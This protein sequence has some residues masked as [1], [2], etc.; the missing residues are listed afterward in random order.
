MTDEVNATLRDA[1]IRLAASTPAALLT[2]EHCGGNFYAKRRNT[3]FCSS[4]CSNERKRH[5]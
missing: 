2:C 4:Q 1:V 5:A 3:R